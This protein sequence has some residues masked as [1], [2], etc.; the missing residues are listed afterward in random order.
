MSEVTILYDG[1][2]PVCSRVAAMQHLHRR[3]DRV[4]LVDARSAPGLVADYRRRGFEINDGFIID[5]HNGRVHF[6]AEAMAYIA[7]AERGLP[8]SVLMLPFVS[9]RFGAAVYPALKFGRRVLLKCL[10]IS[11]R[12]D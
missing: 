3:F 1:D 11:P 10:G 9:R 8:K 5:E 4:E 12:I 7:A 6:G 2:C